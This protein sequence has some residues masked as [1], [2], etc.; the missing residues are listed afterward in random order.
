MSIPTNYSIVA[1]GRHLHLSHKAAVLKEIANLATTP[2]EVIPEASRF[3]LEIDLL[4]I[5]K[6][7]LTQQE[8]WIAAMTAA[9]SAGRRCAH[10]R[11]LHRTRIRSIPNGESLRLRRDKHRAERRMA[12][13]L[14]Q[15]RE[16]T[17]LTYGKWQLKRLWSGNDAITN[18]SNKR[19]RKPD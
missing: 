14:N 5:D 2:P 18:G 1:Q 17:D 7:T 10:P 12:T 6:S 19:L 8:Y 9:I 15:I 11:H 13:L 4:N 3:L 16:D